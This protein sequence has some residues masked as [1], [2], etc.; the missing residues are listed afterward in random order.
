MQLSMHWICLRGSQ[1][2]AFDFLVHMANEK[3]N[4]L[5]FAVNAF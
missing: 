2:G 3:H 4:D 1:G 5:C